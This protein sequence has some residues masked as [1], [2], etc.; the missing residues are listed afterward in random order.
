MEFQSEDRLALVLTGLETLVGI[1]ADLSESG[2]DCTTLKSLI[3][4]TVEVFREPEWITAS[5]I[6]LKHYQ[7]SATMLRQCHSLEKDYPA[8]GDGS[9]T[10]A[11]ADV[12]SYLFYEKMIV[13]KAFGGLASDCKSSESDQLHGL[14]EWLEIKE[15][16]EPIWA[17]RNHAKDLSRNLRLVITHDL[18]E[19]QLRT[20]TED[21]LSSM[22]IL[23]LGAKIRK[24][25]SSTQQGLLD[26]FLEQKI[27]AMKGSNA[28]TSS[29]NHTPSTSLTADSTTPE[30]SVNNVGRVCNQSTMCNDASQAARSNT[31]SSQTP[32]LPNAA[33]VDGELD[34]L[35]KK[36]Q[37][38]E[39]ANSGLMVENAQTAKMNAKLTHENEQKSSSLKKR[40]SE[41]AQTKLILAEEKEAYAIVC[42][43]SLFLSYT[44]L[45]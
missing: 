21:D 26:R 39:A 38:L 8:S 27:S 44:S 14:E 29:A 24:D 5:S 35:Q 23:K 33:A 7:R 41:K 18:S 9:V 40:K 20:E 11:M 10:N 16:M 1:W 17:F 32:F 30:Q 43:I 12:I 15:S 36:I 25:L 4:Q 34:T 28:T 42:I 3:T 13:H 31:A 37:E 45:S 6:N 19:L 2:A 22:D